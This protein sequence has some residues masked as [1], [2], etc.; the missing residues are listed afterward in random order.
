VR[1][2]GL[3]PDG[4]SIAPEYEDVVTALHLEGCTIIKNS[5]LAPYEAD[6]ELEYIAPEGQAFQMTGRFTVESETSDVEHCCRPI[7]SRQRFIDTHQEEIKKLQALGMSAV[8][9][10]EVFITDYNY[11]ADHDPFTPPEVFLG[12]NLAIR[13]GQ[14]DDSWGLVVKGPVDAGTEPGIRTIKL[15]SGNGCEYT[16][17][18]SVPNA[19]FWWYREVAQGFFDECRVELVPDEEP[20]AKLWLPEDRS[21]VLWK[22]GDNAYPDLIDQYGPIGGSFAAAWAESTIRHNELFPKQADEADEIAF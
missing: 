2:V 16:T 4:G 10:F 20:E 21:E 11:W 18:M 6:N 12:R 14:H 7:E 1:N 22:S 13:S 8:Q 9:A 17:G 19:I 5:L 15:P 3:A